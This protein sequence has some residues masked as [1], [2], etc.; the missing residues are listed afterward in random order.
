MLFLT[1]GVPNQDVNL[2]VGQYRRLKENYP[3]MFINGIQYEMGRSMS[4]N[5]INISYLQ[6]I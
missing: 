6:S 1:D 3:Y 2:E 5:I 4:Q